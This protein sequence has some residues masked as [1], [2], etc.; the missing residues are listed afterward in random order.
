MKICPK[1]QRSAKVSERIETDK[2][3]KKN[4]L[5]TFCAKCGHNYDL[6]EYKGQV[7]SPQEEMDKYQSKGPQGKFWPTI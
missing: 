6:E 1:C 4:W 7:L 3:A 2:K 5:I